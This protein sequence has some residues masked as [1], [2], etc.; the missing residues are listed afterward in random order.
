MSKTYQ[1]FQSEQLALTKNNKSEWVY[2][3]YLM[4]GTIFFLLYW[5]AET[6][7]PLPVHFA[8]LLGIGLGIFPLSR[9]LANK[10]ESLPMI[11]LVCLSLAIQ[12]STPVYF[13]Y[14]SVHLHS[15]DRSF[16]WDLQSQ[17]L[18]IIAIGI[19]TFSKSYSF[20][21]SQFTKLSSFPQIYLRLAPTKITIFFAAGVILGITVKLFN[22]STGL[23]LNEE[24]RI[25]G[26]WQALISIM[27][28]FSSVNLI[29]MIE[30]YYTDRLR[31]NLWFII[32]YGVIYINILLG[33]MSG[34]LEETIFPIVLLIVSY[35]QVKKKIPYRLI[36]CGIALFMFLQ[37]LKFAYREKAF[38]F[39]NQE[40]LSIGAKINLWAGILSGNSANTGEVGYE[41]QFRVS[42]SRLD[43]YH[44]FVLVYD[45]CPTTIPYRF[46]ESYSYL[47]YAWIP[48]IVWPNKPFAQQSNIDFSLDYGVQ[49][50]EGALTTMNGV[51]YLGEAYSNFGMIGVTLIM[52]ALGG[53]FA[54]LQTLLTHP[55]SEGGRA[56]YLA[57]MVS[58]LNGIGS[59]LAAFIGGIVQLIIINIILI[60]LFTIRKNSISK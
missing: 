44:Q 6:T 20:C 3:S 18:I 1:V 35:S 38:D 40:K 28:A 17:V 34:M 43:Y 37:P 56:L 10:R 41:E 15:G 59:N 26:T 36:I 27:T 51:G 55:E 14:N 13:Q 58:C 46:G 12:Y 45:L 23:S 33:L 7:M 8:S 53:F 25:I 54:V 48:R 32:L 4:I 60:K 49:S 29:L 57:I 50:Y 2:F 42:M 22:I 16:D 9:W 19:L 11:E 21:L 47:I 52:G 30:Y 5:Q 39:G 24:G 31:G